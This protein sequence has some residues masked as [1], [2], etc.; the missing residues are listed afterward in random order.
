MTAKGVLYTIPKRKLLTLTFIQ[1]KMKKSIYIVSALLFQ[2]LISKAQINYLDNYINNTP[3]LTT[4]GTSTD[5][6]NQPRDLDFK[7]GT[8]ELWV[9]NY[10]NTNGGTVI[11]F[12]NAGLQDQSSEFRYDDHSDHFFYYPS[13]IALSDIG[14]FGAV[15]EIQNS[16]ANSPTFMG[17]S[18]WLTDT[19][20]FAKVWQNNWAS[21]YP[22]GSHIDMLHQ[23]PFAMGI[24][25]DSAEAYWV[26]DGYNGNICK[27]DFVADHGPGYDNHSAGKIWR[28]QDVTVTRVPQVP[29]HMIVDKINK[30]LYF[31]DGGTKK[32][33]RMNINTGI[34]SGNL[35]PPSTGSESLG[36]YKKVLG[37]TVET[38]DS[39]G[40][41]PCGMDYYNDRLIVSDYTTGDIYLYNTSGASVTIMDTIVTGHPGMMGIKVGPD[42]HIW[43]VNK[44][45]NKI[46]RLDAGR[47]MLDASIEKISS[48]LLENCVSNYYSPGFNLCS[49]NINPSVNITNT[50]TDT[51]VSMEIHYALDG[52]THTTYNWSGSLPTD[53]TVLITLPS[54]TVA[55]GRHQLDVMI[56]MVNGMPDNVDL[57][58]L[59]IGSFRAFSPIQSLPFN[60]DFSSNTFP[61]LNWS[62]VHFNTNNYLSRATVSGFGIGS[63]SMKMNNFSGPMNITGQKDY[64]MSPLVDLSTA[65][66]NTYLQF[67]VAYAKYASADVDE[68]QIVVSTDCGSSWNPIYDKSGTALSTAPLVTSAFTPTN[69][70]WRTDSVNLSSLIG[71]SEVMLMFTSISNYGN[72][73]Y[74]DNIYVGALNVGIQDV[75][76]SSAF[77]VYP[78]PATNFLNIETSPA[79]SVNK[80]VTVTDVIGKVIIR[81]NISDP[82]K[83]IQLNISDWNNGFYFITIQSGELSNTRKIC[84][85]N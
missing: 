85:I 32:V 80:I 61:P 39:L 13:A 37:A 50:G 54:G 72:N 33:K 1:T 69:S 74:L 65:P 40:T 75:S 44:T 38:I 59:S 36:L 43:C 66:S 29:S 58:N 2:V 27:Y 45:E 35:T 25:H 71:Q 84:K 48:P 11:I 52:G 70:Q 67:D 20:I 63:G 24:A 9:C 64:L 28:Y 49:G 30:W 3:A 23:S 26:M 6:L 53:S 10:G 22:L 12:Y 31:I 55:Y 73:V 78:N 47:P 76:N 14:Q 16:N 34:I 46:Y 68:L 15:S 17:P 82:Q 56:M 42:G 79:M 8:N 21:G 41:Q 51:I 7:P 60:E 62:Y 18:L 77:K 83:N 57:N 81:R 5:Q 19:S 4:I